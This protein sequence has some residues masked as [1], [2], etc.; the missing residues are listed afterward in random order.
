MIK[1]FFISALLLSVTPAFAESTVQS[2]STVTNVVSPTATQ[3]VEKFGDKLDQYI[4]VLASKAGVAADHFYPIFV[5]QQVITGIF[6]LS[7]MAIGL[8]SGIGLICLGISNDSEKMK[9]NKCLACS[10]AA[11]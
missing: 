2:G 3:L 10:A 5:R 1:T 7:L 9:P 4:T 6:E 11:F 8:I